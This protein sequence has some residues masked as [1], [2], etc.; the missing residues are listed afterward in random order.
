MT[1]LFANNASGVLQS[2]INNT[3]D[4]VVLTLNFGEGAQ[5]PQP[6]GGDTFLVTLQD[7]SGAIEIMLATDRVGDVIT[8][9]RAQEGTIAL[10]FSAGTR[11]EIRSTA[12]TL[13]NFTQDGAPIDMGG[14][15][16]SNASV[17]TSAWNGGTMQAGVYRSTAGLDGN[18]ITIP[19]QE[20]QNPHVD[21]DP[22]VLLSDI[23][24]GNPQ[25]D[26]FYDVVYPVG[27]VT[28]F[29]ANI[30]PNNIVGLPAGVTWEQILDAEDKFLMFRELNGRPPQQTFDGVNVTFSG[31]DHTHGG[32]DGGGETGDTALTVDQMPSHRHAMG[33]GR[34]ASDAFYVF[35][36]P[37]GGIAT[38]PGGGVAENSMPPN[39]ELEGGGQ[40]HSHFIQQGGSH[41]HNINVIPAYYVLL[42]WRRIA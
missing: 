11:V 28:F 3:D 13:G 30:N 10:P 25:L 15:T 7:G 34:P 8:A 14:N 31:G 26:A 33:Y 6:T 23:Q 12:G 19:D 20:N 1:T 36:S 22:I 17:A 16:L 32:P 29:D 18:A 41:V 21:G 35:A 38:T 24:T 9:T 27:V 4:P 42:P 2:P 40:T 37:T 5:F 39:T